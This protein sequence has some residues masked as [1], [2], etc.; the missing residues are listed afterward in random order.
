[1]CVEPRSGGRDL[2]FERVF[3]DELSEPDGSKSDFDS[4]FGDAISGFV[5]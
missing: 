5:E 2:S 3:I 1:M 4:W